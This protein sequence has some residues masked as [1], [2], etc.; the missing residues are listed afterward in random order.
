MPLTNGRQKLPAIID[1][2]YSY[3]QHWER[4]VPDGWSLQMSDDAI[5]RAVE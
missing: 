5:S 1:R 2:G 4:P 3:F